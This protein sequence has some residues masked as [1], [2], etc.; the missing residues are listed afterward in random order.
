MQSVHCL[1]VESGHFS[2]TAQPMFTGRQ[3]R[4]GSLSGVFMGFHYVA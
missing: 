3:L 4:R 2:L 1:P